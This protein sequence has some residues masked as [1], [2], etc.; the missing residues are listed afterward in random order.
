MGLQC[1][2]YKVVRI[3]GMA[4]D[5]M[6]EEI[7][8]SQNDRGRLR[9]DLSGVTGGNRTAATTEK[10][11]LSKGEE[12]FRRK[13][14]MVADRFGFR[15]LEFV[16]QRAL[17]GEARLKTVIKRFIMARILRGSVAS[18]RDSIDM[19]ACPGYPAWPSLRRTCR[20]SLQEGDPQRFAR[21]S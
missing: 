2:F 8:G 21:R 19:K 15:P 13:G 6:L 11:L 9:R 18:V 17:A 1:R 3:C 16:Y 14:S 20:R 5:K 7:P 10:F 4:R 12:A